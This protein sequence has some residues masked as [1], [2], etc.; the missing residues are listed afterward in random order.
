MTFLYKQ[1]DGYKFPINVNKNNLL[2]I[3]KNFVT[4]KDDIIICSNYR[5]GSTLLQFIINILVNN[6]RITDINLEWLEMTGKKN[7][8]VYKTHCSYTNLP[9]KELNSDTKIIYIQRDVKDVFVS[10]YEYYKSSTNINYEGDLNTFFNLFMKG[11]LL[12]DR[13][14]THIKSYKNSEHNNI[15]FIKY[16]DLI[17]NKRETILEIIKFLELTVNNKK[18][19]NIIDV[20]KFDYMKNKIIKT[21]YWKTLINANHPQFFRKGIVGDNKNYNLSDNQIK[22][23]DLLSIHLR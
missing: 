2:E 19:K 3:K 12:Y 6:T 11:D 15:L 1:I 23:L 16:E 9:I 7:N 4:D 17:N 13:W 21:N 20:T 10:M 5:S 22:L 18:I 14:D 8:R